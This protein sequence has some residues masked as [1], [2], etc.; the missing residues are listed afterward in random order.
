DQQ[1]PAG[2]QALPA[3]PPV[4]QKAKDFREVPT[5]ELPWHARHSP[6]FIE[7]R[8]ELHRRLSL[9]VGCLALALMG[10]P[11]GI[12]SRNGGKSGGYVTAVFLAFLC[13]CL[14]FLSLIGLAEQQKMPVWLA[15]W[16]PNIAFS[17]CGI[18]LLARLERPGDRDVLGSIQDW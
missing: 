2:D 1:F 14:S 6:K 4:E 11:L 8:I 3:N 16:A 10:I 17:L 12:S 7:A 18:V 15:A 5:R 13:Y 9:P